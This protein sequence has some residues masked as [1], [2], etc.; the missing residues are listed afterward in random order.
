MVC[1][2]RLGSAEGPPL[3]RMDPT[4]NEPYWDQQVS[5][6]FYYNHTAQAQ[7]WAPAW[8]ERS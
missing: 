7:P 3:C 4:H 5:G 8:T 1:D 6:G 2:G